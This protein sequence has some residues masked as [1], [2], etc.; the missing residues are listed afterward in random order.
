MFYVRKN[1]WV[2]V[3][4]ETAQKKDEDKRFIYVKI[5]VDGKAVELSTKRR[6]E[7]SKWNAHAGRAT[8]TKEATKELNQFLDSFEQHVFHVKVC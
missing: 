3:L 4:F 7:Q 2:I 1:V 8:G 6:C 5:T